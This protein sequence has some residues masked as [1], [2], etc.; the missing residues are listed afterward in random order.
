MNEWHSIIWTKHALKRIIERRIDKQDAEKVIQ[1]PLETIVDKDN[2][3]YKCFGEI[4]EKEPK[5]L[6]VNYAI[7]NQCA[8][9]I[10]VMTTGKGGLKKDGFSRI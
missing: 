7:N 5:Y 9:I 10:T 1:N 8:K 6:I 2:N 4:Y 3:N